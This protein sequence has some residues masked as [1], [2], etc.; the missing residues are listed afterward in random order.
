MARLLEYKYISAT[1]T[2]VCTCLIEEE[3]PDDLP[4]RPADPV[5]PRAQ[6]SKAD[7]LIN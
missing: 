6:R 7:L 3:V 1:D 4:A 5:P 2:F